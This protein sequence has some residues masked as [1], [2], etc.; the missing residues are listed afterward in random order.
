MPNLSGIETCKRLI[1]MGYAGHIIGHS[2]YQATDE[3]EACLNAGMKAYF[4]KPLDQIKLQ[5]WLE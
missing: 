3:E 1:A 4:V 2:G 5:Q